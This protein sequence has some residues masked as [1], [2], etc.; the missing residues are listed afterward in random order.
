MPYKP[1]L[2]GGHCISVD[3]YYL[4]YKADQVGYHPQ[5]IL[6]GR[7]VNNSIAKFIA[8]KTMKLMVTRGKNLKEAN[9]LLLGVTFKENFEDVRNTKVVDMASELEDFGCC[10][11]L[12]DPIADEN[13]FKSLYNRDLIREIDKNKS[14]DAIIVC[15]AHDI[16][17]TF[18]FNLCF[19]YL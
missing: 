16:F 15:V 5:V 11:D 1:G 9:V 2:V 4:L 3:P 14:Y 17:K 8:D 10:V 13:K 7:N 12:Y 18:D 19:S 6:S